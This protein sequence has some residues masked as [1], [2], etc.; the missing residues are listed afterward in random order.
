MPSIDTEPR[1]PRRTKAKVERLPRRAAAKKTKRR[2]GPLSKNRH[3][4]YQEAVQSPEEHVKFFDRVYADRHGH[5]ARSLKEDF[6]GTAFL[7]AG[8]VSARPDNT[9]VG[10][11]L[12]LPTLE[13]GRRHNLDPLP[14]EARGR[15]T[16]LHD[17]VRNVTRPE[18]DIVAAL[19]FSY[20]EFKTRDAL[21][22]YFERVRES[23]RPGGMLVIDMFGGWDAQMEVT[24]KTRN[25]GFTYIWE[26]T[27]FDPV[28]H[29]TQFHIHFKIHGE[30]RTIRKAFEYNWRLWTL[31]EVRELLAEAG[32]AGSDVYWE[33]TDDDTGEGNGEFERVTTAENCPGWI[34]L[35]VAARD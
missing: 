25:R 29:L 35:V 15:V 30:D 2:I 13:W 33:Q 24:D 27:K 8:W 14:D 3:W 7:S 11:D 31:P 23:L 18:V 32:F 12:D 16:L 34:A 9:A 26:Q 17:D 10:V 19:N 6:C 21:R 1:N 22:A 28:T 5:P 4:L 20:F